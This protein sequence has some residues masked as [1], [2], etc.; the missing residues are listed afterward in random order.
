MLTAG[1]MLKEERAKKKLTLDEV[2]SATKI[3][4]S[5]LAAL[6]LDEYEKFPSAV[7]AR[8]FLQNYAKYL[9][10]DV[11]KVIAL[12]RRSV[13]DSKA[14]PHIKESSRKPTSPKFVLTPG[15]LIVAIVSILALATVGYLVYQFYNFQKPP[16]LTVVSPRN[17]EVLDIDTVTVQGSTDPGMFV[18]INDEAIKIDDEGAFETEVGLSKGSNTIIVKS[19]HPDNVGKEAVVQVTVEY[20]P[21][22]EGE[23]ENSTED[24]AQQPEAPTSFDLS[25]TVSTESAW[26]EIT[27][28]QTQMFASVAAPGSTY[29]YTAT[30]SI[31]VRTGRASATQ[32]QIN[33]EVKTPYSEAAGIASILCELQNSEVSC[34][35]P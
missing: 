16:E 13:A 28:D 10:M 4:A 25:V 2:A 21:D 3:N 27:V 6:E 33:D 20:V 26:L 35:Q 11:E 19:R 31:Q 15:A 7:Y 23:E 14:T 12:Y 32:I 17:A 1:S 9:D 24:A 5:Y 29:T 8:G 30:N 18:T 22:D 34:R